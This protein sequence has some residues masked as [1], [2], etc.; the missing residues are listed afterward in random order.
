MPRTKTVKNRNLS[1]KKQKQH[2]KRI[3]LAKLSRISKKDNTLEEDYQDLR[4]YYIAIALMNISQFL[5]EQGDVTWGGIVD[6]YTLTVEQ[7]Y[8]PNTNIKINDNDKS[9]INSLTTT[10]FTN[11]PTWDLNNIKSYIPYQ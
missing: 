1:K 8:W 10:L 7:D 11:D 9:R 5:F 2:N 3:K 4:K 6:P